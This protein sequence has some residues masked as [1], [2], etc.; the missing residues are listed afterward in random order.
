MKKNWKRYFAGFAIA[1]LVCVALTMSYYAQ[2]AS[3]VRYRLV[4]EENFDKRTLDIRHWNKIARVWPEWGKYMSSLDT[5]YEFRDGYLRLYARINDGIAPQDTAPYLTGGIS[6]RHRQTFTY[7]KVEVRARMKGVKGCWPAIWIRPDDWNGRS[8]QEQAEIDVMEYYNT[9]DI[10]WCTIHNSHTLIDKKTEDPV[11]K[12]SAR[13]R[14][15]KYNVYTMEIL[16]DKLVWSVNGKRK[17][18]YPRVESAGFRQYPFGEPCYLMIDM[19]VGNPWLR[20]IDRASFPAYMDID[21]V[22]FYEC[23]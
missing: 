19:Q 22:R 8:Y 2:A 17:F 4:W 20:D 12:Q 3:K 15:G 10:V 1:V 13:I 16:P 7:G 11:S 14:R 21:W 9:D 23:E 18:T 6:T 5:L